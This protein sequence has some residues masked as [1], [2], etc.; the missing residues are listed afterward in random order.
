MERFADNV[1][2]DRHENIRIVE[3]NVVVEIWDL[4]PSS[5]PVIG[6]AAESQI[7]K[8]M[9]EP[10]KAEKIATVF[11]SSQLIDIDVDAAIE[12]PKEVFVQQENGILS[13][14]SNSGH[15]E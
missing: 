9:E 4:K 2:L 6:L 11:N 12:L 7:I 5:R 15:Q 14:I 8:S 3:D 1:K 10:F 13:Y